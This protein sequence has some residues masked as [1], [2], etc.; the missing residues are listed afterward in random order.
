MLRSTPLRFLLA[1]T[2]A[3]CATSIRAEVNERAP[4][5]LLLAYSHRVAATPATIC[6][7]V[8]QIERWWSGDHTS[9]GKATR[10]TSQLRR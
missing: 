2:L 9:S 10:R 4:D 1:G 7:A 8:G 6:D 3:N 5:S